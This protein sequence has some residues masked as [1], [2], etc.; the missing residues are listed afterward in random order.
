MLG[1]AAGHAWRA[2]L[3]GA[4]T[5]LLAGCVGGGPPPAPP[6]TPTPTPLPVTLPTL[7][8]VGTLTPEPTLG[9][10]PTPT[11]PPAAGPGESFHSQ[12]YEYDVVVP[13]GWTAGPGAGKIGSITADL[14]TGPTVDGFPTTVTVIAQPLPATVVDTPTFFRTQIAGL[15]AVGAQ[16][17]VVGSVPV[18]SSRA[19][20]VTYLNRRPDNQSL[21]SRVHQ[22][23]FVLRSRGWALSLQTAERASDSGLAD[24]KDMLASFQ[25]R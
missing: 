3:L 16:I 4:A 22:V 9:P 21:F 14:F 25:P 6:P 13:K 20:L 10:T 23:F 24:F 5:L 17:N 1:T 12:L 2:G 8:S 19:T 15:Q 11:V 18:D 7:A